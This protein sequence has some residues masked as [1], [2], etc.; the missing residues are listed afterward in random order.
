VPNALTSVVMFFFAS[1][2]LIASTTGFALF[3]RKR[4]MLCT[5][6]AQLSRGPTI[7]KPHH[8]HVA[9][10]H[11]KFDVTDRYGDITQ[12]LRSSQPC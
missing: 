4:F 11:V 2:R 8:C 9:V 5:P 6:V 10:A 7:I 1:G 3:D 12:L